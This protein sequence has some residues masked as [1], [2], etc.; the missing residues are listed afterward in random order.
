MPTVKVFCTNANI[1]TASL[2]NKPNNYWIFYGIGRANK[3]WPDRPLGRQEGASARRRGPTAR[4]VAEGQP[5]VRRSGP[6]R[7]RVQQH[8]QDD[9]AAA[10]GHGS[11]GQGPQRAAGHHEG[12]AGHGEEEQEGQAV[13][14]RGRGLR[15]RQIAIVS[16]IL[17]QL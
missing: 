2:S 5:P 16:R 9:G 3:P 1:F 10:E 4:P 11:G 7:D 6:L 14:R 12:E 17:Y 13:P 8:A 15:S